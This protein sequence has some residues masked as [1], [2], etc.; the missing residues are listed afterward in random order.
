M[1][2][3]Q[4]ALLQFTFLVG[5]V[6]ALAW[7]FMAILIGVQPRASKQFVAAN[8]LMVL[9]VVLGGL[10]ETAPSYLHYHLADWALLS[11]FALK[12]RG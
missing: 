2:P 5:L 6:F 3:V 1:N 11:G 10:R 12:H 8:G 4:H 7:L 9:G